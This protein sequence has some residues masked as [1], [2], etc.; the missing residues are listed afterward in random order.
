MTQVPF[1]RP[2]LCFATLAVICLAGPAGCGSEPAAKPAPPPVDVKVIQTR[3]QTV[4]VVNEYVGRAAAYRSVEVNAR[5][6][7]IVERRVFTEGTDVKKGDLLY[8]IESDT[9]QKN[10]DNA[11]ATLRRSQADLANAIAKEQRLAP[12]LKEDAISRQDYDDALT[13]VKQQQ[14]AVDSA[15]AALAAAKIDL[16]YTQILATESGRIGQTLVPEGR[17]VGK[18]GPTHMATIDKI[19]QMYVVFTLADRDALIL[20]RAAEAGQITAGVDA[21]NVRVFLPDGRQY[22]RGGKLDFTDQQ[23][24]P[25]TGTITLRGVLPN[26]QRELLPGM[27]VRVLLDVGQR[28]NSVLVPQ[29]AVLKTPTGHNVWVVTKDNKVERRDLVMGPWYKEDWIVE[30]GLAAGETVIID[31]IQKVRAGIE[32]KTSPYTA[33]AAKP[34]AAAPP[35]LE[36]RTAAK[37]AGK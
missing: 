16:G 27:F 29:A 31:G 19:D 1:A 10:V 37:P 8:V 21:G 17:L 34:A 23:V 3:E 12:L 25:D 9:F 6:Q 14:A 32:V 30:K 26:P 20:R 4:P 15:Q 2:A 18:D 36:A 22:T 35:A 7:G 33:P 11:Q 5:V 28:P 24:N 13:A